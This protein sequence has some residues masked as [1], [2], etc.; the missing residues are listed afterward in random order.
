MKLVVFPLPSVLYKVSPRELSLFRFIPVLTVPTFLPRLRHFHSI[1]LPKWD[2]DFVYNLSPIPLPLF[3][4]LFFLT[5][6][7]LHFLSFS[8]EILSILQKLNS[9]S[10]C[11]LRIGFWSSGSQIVPWIHRRAM[12]MH[13]TNPHIVH[14]KANFFCC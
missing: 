5:H 9:L 1:L 2:I 13:Q 11:V 4:F 12:Y 14:V 8:A 10:L 3:H 6:I 7:C